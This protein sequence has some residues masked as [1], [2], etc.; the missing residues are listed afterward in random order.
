M[1]AQYTCTSFYNTKHHSTEKALVFLHLQILF[2]TLYTQILFH[3]YAVFQECYT[4][5]KKPHV[6]GLL[7]SVQLKNANFQDMLLRK[8]K[9]IMQ[10]YT[11][12]QFLSN[13]LKCH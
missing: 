2:H 8:Q 1:R 10:S 12:V 9:E 13:P 7:N 5:N 3:P 4:Y 11:A 6:C